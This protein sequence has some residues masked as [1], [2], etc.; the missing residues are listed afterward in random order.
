[1]ARPLQ[2][3]DDDDTAIRHKIARNIVDL[4][5]ILIGARIELTN[6]ENTVIKST[7]GLLYSIVIIPRRPIAAGHTISNITS[8]RDDI[9]NVRYGFVTAEGGAC[10]IVPPTNHRKRK[11]DAPPVDLRTP[12][13]HPAHAE[14]MNPRRLRKLCTAAAAVDEKEECFYWFWPSESRFERI[15]C[16]ACPSKSA[17]VALP[18][19]VLRH[20]LPATFFCQRHLDDWHAHCRAVRTAVEDTE[21]DE[22][23]KQKRFDPTGGWEDSAETRRHK[24]RRLNESVETA[25]AAALGAFEAV[26]KTTSAHDHPDIAATR[27]ALAPKAPTRS[28]DPVAWFSGL[29]PIEARAW[30]DNQLAKVDQS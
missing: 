20:D 21:E 12:W 1:M 7:N 29:D 8:N 17:N 22:D 16:C 2:R 19:I 30:L 26:L 11:I 6:D 25:K 5:D 4:A 24:R 10:N 23:E 27:R 14:F 15:M 9:S 18:I 28:V 13:P 3:A